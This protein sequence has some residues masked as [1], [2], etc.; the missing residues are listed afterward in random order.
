MSALYNTLIFA[1]VL[2]VA[3][4]LVVFLYFRMRRKDVA[5][6]RAL[7]L[8]VR[9]CVRQV[10]L[11]QL[12]IG[13]LGILA[14]GCAGWRYTLENAGQT[15]STLAEIVEESGTAMAA[16]SIGWLALLLAVCFALLLILT[17]G[18]AVMTAKRP[19]VIQLQGGTTMARS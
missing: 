5:I 19:V 15:L 8:P 3:L 11:P 14:G 12:L 10:S 7:G 1:V 13:L 17:L 9:R 18:S 6:A 2:A 4:C 16:L